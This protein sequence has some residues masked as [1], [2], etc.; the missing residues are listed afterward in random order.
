[1]SA[2]REEQESHHLVGSYIGFGKGEAFG[3]ALYVTGWNDLANRT[4]RRTLNVSL[5]IRR[6]GIARRMAA[7]RPRMR[8]GSIS[9]FL[10]YPPPPR[11]GTTYL[12]ERSLHLQCY[13][14]H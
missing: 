11:H 4:Y 3:T 2:R 10:A 1:M 12:V 13:V 7:Y 5:G 9:S 14:Y 6:F 8:L